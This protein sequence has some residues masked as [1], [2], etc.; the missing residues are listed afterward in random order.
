MLFKPFVIFTTI[1]SS[2]LAAPSPAEIEFRALCKTPKCK[3]YC[4][5]GTAYNCC[6]DYIRDPC[7]GHY[8]GD[9]EK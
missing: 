2:V 9:V 6:V 7:W 4:Q 5:D 8:L 3:A 1:L